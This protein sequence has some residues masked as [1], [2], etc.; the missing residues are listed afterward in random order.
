ML[1]L[2]A[3]RFLVERVTIDNVVEKPRLGFCNPSDLA[4]AARKA[5]IEMRAALH[6]E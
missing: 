2:A 1:G 4:H 6:Y 3:A 5:W